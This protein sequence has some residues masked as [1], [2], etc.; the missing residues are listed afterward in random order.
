MH[1]LACV[2]TLFQPYNGTV[3]VSDVENNQS[4]KYEVITLSYFNIYE[5]T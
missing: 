1:H 3:E 4:P 5:I 2:Q